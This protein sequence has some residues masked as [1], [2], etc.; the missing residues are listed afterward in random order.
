MEGGEIE[1]IE[2]IDNERPQN[3][4]ASRQSNDVRAHAIPDEATKHCKRKTKSMEDVI[5]D[6]FKQTQS[7]IDMIYQ[8]GLENIDMETF[9]S[10]TA[11]P[12]TCM[13]RLEED[14]LKPSNGARARMPLPTEGNGKGSNGQNAPVGSPEMDSLLTEVSQWAQDRQQWLLADGKLKESNTRESSMTSAT[15]EEKAIEKV[16]RSNANMK[17]RCSNW[18]HDQR[19][20]SEEPE[21]VKVGGILT[22]PKLFRSTAR[23]PA[24]RTVSFGDSDDG[25]T[26]RDSSNH[27]SVIRSEPTRV[28]VPSRRASSRL[29]ILD[30][31]N[32]NDDVIS[33]VKSENNNGEGFPEPWSPDMYMSVSKCE[34]DRSTLNDNLSELDEKVGFRARS[35]GS[36]LSSNGSCS[37]L[38]KEQ[39]INDADDCFEV[40]RGI[41]GTPDTAR[42]PDLSVVAETNVVKATNVAKSHQILRQAP[43]VHTPFKGLDKTPVP[44]T[45]AIPNR[46][47]LKNTQLKPLSL[48]SSPPKTAIDHFPA[49]PGMKGTSHSFMTSRNM[50]NHDNTSVMSGNRPFSEIPLTTSDYSLNRSNNGNGLP[51]GPDS[52]HPYIQAMMRPLSETTSQ[53][54]GGKIG[55]GPIMATKDKQTYARDIINA[56]EKQR[57]QPQQDA[58]HINIPTP[59]PENTQEEE[60][61]VESGSKTEEEPKKKRHKVF[62]N[63]LIRGGYSYDK[64]SRKDNRDSN[65]K[66]SQSFSG[67]HGS[68]EQA[69]LTYSQSFQTGSNPA[70]ASVSDLMFS[71]RD[72]VNGYGGNM[73]SAHNDTVPT[74]VYEHRYMNGYQNS[75][76]LQARN[77]NMEPANVNRNNSLQTHSLGSNYVKSDSSTN[78]G[79]HQTAEKFRKLRSRRD[80]EMEWLMKDAAETEV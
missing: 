78:V 59:V 74:Q 44:T 57:L 38:M 73:T 68:N 64:H 76:S 47:L 19:Q 55:M 66:N 71:M 3:P 15:M 1:D 33:A 42:T 45:P 23:N 65:P 34:L 35:P 41:N 37:N 60:T 6:L 31:H 12:D 49:L 29:Q 52:S 32:D 67:K 22:G 39:D 58:F 77:A 4:M 51:Q 17:D 11:T 30:L 54:R 20:L 27:S 75:D 48:R 25:E 18:V 46:P 50:N 62:T 70:T 14:L 61:Q 56:I 10:D 21:T 2:D 13:K 24:K 36:W 8:N 7:N 79:H 5:D 72:S 9:R 26:P 28:E 80:Q 40:P 16:S 69:P 53:K 43:K 63:S